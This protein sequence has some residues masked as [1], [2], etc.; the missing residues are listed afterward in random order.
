MTTDITMARPGDEAEILR[1][2]KALA[3]YERMPDA[4]K[5]TEES[6]SAT[7]FDDQPRVWAHLARQDG[8][9]VGVALWFLTYSTW[10]G[11]PT[12]YLEDLFVEEAARGTGAGVAL[13]RAL[14]AEAG[15][16]GCGRM[17]W[18][19]LDWNE[20]AKDFYRRMGAAPTSGWEGW[21]IEGA[22]LDALASA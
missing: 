15:R 8:R 9:V 2:I 14:A 16:R 20:P 11:S 1:L 7:L 4:V 19:V 17:D 12:L 21:R 3:A 5:A 13:F 22:A 18:A 6:L 10:T